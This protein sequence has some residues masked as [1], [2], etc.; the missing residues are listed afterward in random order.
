MTNIVNKLKYLKKIQQIEQNIR[1]SSWAHTAKELLVEGYLGDREGEALFNLAKYGSGNGEIVEIGSWKGRSTIYLAKGSKEAKREKITA[2]D[3]FKGS[4]EHQS[5]LEG[6]STYDDFLDNIKN[7]KVDDYIDI[8]KTS[9]EEA[10][11]NW[12]KPIRL[13]FIDGAHEYDM[14]KNDFLLWEPF[15]INN[16]IIAFHDVGS[17]DG[18]TR[19]IEEYIR[20]S[21]KFKTITQIGSIFI[22]IKINN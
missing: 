18:P 16:G 22:A 3:T 4:S 14:V 13:L 6:R 1:G 21:N 12:K 10:S 19:V 9:S 17:F 8:L 5:I 11:N 7:W 20:N 15:L 2:I